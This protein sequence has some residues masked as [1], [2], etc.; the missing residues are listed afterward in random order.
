MA[1]HAARA[2]RVPGPRRDRRVPPRSG[3]TP[4][5]SAAGGANPRQYPAGVRLLSPHQRYRH[6]ATARA[7]RP[8]PP[9]RPD[10]RDNVVRR[11]QRLPALR[12][13]ADLA[14][15]TLRGG[16][17]V[18]VVAVPPGRGLFLVATEWR[19]VQ[20]PVGPHQLLD[21]AVVGGVGVVHD[22][23]LEREGAHPLSLGRDL[24]DVAEVVLGPVPLLLLCE[25][26]TE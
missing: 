21:S 9:G 1:D 6:R 20:H 8:H 15:G 23:V 25:G 12:T 18:L 4:R 24:V 2:A 10:L 13:T 11:E 3:G 26:S 5:R 22:A 14:L 19:Q 17:L 16:G 7:V